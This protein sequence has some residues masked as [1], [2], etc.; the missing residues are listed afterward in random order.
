MPSAPCSSRSAVT[1]CH[2]RQGLKGPQQAGRWRGGASE[3][4]AWNTDRS[5]QS[6]K[7][8]PSIKSLLDR[9]DEL[10]Q[11]EQRGDVLEVLVK[12]CAPPVL[13]RRDEERFGE[14]AFK[15]F[16][17]NRSKKKIRK[18]EHAGNHLKKTCF[19]LVCRV[20]VAAA[21]PRAQLIIYIY[22]IFRL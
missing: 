9:L 11:A 18:D 16:V 13:G 22:I 20:C 5:I 15:P 14:E 17:Y 19:H 10:R 7:S 6:M 21:D 12:K 8:L 2:E 1:N 3:Q 4:E